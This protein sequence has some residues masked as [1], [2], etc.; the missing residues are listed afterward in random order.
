MTLRLLLTT[1]CIL[2]SA[3]AGRPNAGQDVQTMSAAAKSH[4]P[5]EPY[6][7]SM[8]KLNSGLTKIMI[9]PVV[10]VYRALL[11]KP[12]R[13]GIANISANAKA[14]LVFVHD[15][16]QGEAQRASQTLGRFLMNSTVGIGGSIDMAAKAGVPPHDE[17]AGQTFARWG[18]PSG[19][20]LMLPLLGPSTVRDSFGFAADIFADPLRYVLRS[21]TLPIGFATSPAAVGVA[22]AERNRGVRSDVGTGLMFASILSQLDQN[23]DRLDELHLGAVDPYV[24]LREAYRQFRQADIDN[25]KPKKPNPDDDPLADVLDAPQ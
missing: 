24:A 9:K 17:D 15:I 25:G 18:V 19:P 20:Y 8:M 16:L 4:D 3:C 12:L 23:V 1:L 2:C 6:N 7:R 11:P 22:I 21:Q 10:T 13:Q 14:P 5:F